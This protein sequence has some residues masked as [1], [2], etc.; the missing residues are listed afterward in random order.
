M[1]K[2]KRAAKIKRQMEL[3]NAAKTASRDLTPEEQAEV[4]ALQ[5]EIDAL[6]LEIDSEGD[7]DDGNPDGQRSL[8]GV[9]PQATPPAP[10]PAEDT[11]QAVEAARR[12]IAD[13]M[14]L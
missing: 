5:R 9:Q 10:N 3:I 1:K 12:R 11:R 8:T 2:K 13:I 14:P 6:T 7:S 4:E